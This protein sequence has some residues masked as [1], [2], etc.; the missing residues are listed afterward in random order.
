MVEHFSPL[1][2]TL[3]C[4]HSPHKSIPVILNWEKGRL[5]LQ[6]HTP[7]ESIIEHHINQEFDTRKFLDVSTF[8]LQ[9]SNLIFFFF[10]KTIVH[11]HKSIF[12]ITQFCDEYERGFSLVAQGLTHCCLLFKNLYS[13]NLQFL[14]EVI[15]VRFNAS[16]SRY[17]TDDKVVPK[18]SEF[19][20]H[21][22]QHDDQLFLTAEGLRVPHYRVQSF[23]H[24]LE[25]YF[26]ALF[27]F[28]TT[29]A[30]LSVS[31]LDFRFSVC[32]DLFV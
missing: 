16:R 2:I 14:G 32:S 17:H 6:T 8:A 10:L 20:H 23:M 21:I 25:K 3:K 27:F 11:F 4:L 19:L 29:L 12:Y 5:S 26:G 13:V 22:A 1:S 15:N 31:K 28:R 30:H 7:F 24:E 9:S 18:F